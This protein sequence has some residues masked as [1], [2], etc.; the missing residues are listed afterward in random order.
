MTGWLQELEAPAGAEAGYLTGL[1]ISQL[2]HDAAMGYL[3]AV[4]G[5]ADIEAAAELPV[6]PLLRGLTAQ[7]EAPL[8]SAQRIRIHV[9]VDTRGERSFVLAQ[10][11]HL[12]EDDRLVATGTASLVVVEAST[13]RPTSVPAHVWEQV[14]K[15]DGSEPTAAK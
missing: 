14:R 12:A 5:V 4:M 2:M 3:A 9:R 1:Q 10:A 11:V 15:L 13:F 6:R 7:F 8:M